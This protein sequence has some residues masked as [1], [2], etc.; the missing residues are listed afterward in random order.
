MNSTLKSPSTGTATFEK[1]NPENPQKDVIYE[2]EKAVNALSEPKRKETE[3]K[4]KRTF[5]W[6]R[7]VEETPLG[8]KLVGRKYMEKNGKLSKNRY[9]FYIKNTQTQI[10]N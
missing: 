3:V 8:H 2:F 7:Y 9:F 6:G 4:R 1:W 10:N 5:L